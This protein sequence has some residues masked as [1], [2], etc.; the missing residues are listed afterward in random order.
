MQFP[1]LT[2]SPSYLLDSLYRL[3][4]PKDYEVKD[5]SI[6]VIIPARNEEESLE[7]CIKA[8]QAQTYQPAQIIA[9][10]DGSEDRTEEILKSFDGRVKLIKHEEPKGKAK[11]VMEALKELET[12][13]VVIV[14]G[15]TIPAPTNFEKLRI[16]FSDERVGATCSTVF[17]TQNGNEKNLMEKFILQGRLDE[18]LLSIY[19]KQGQSRRRAL[20]VASGCTVAFRTELLK[21]YGIPQRTETED[22]DLTWLLQQEGY[23]IVYCPDAITFTKEPKTSKSLR[24]Q[25]GRWY[26]GAWE[27]IFLHNTKPLKSKRKRL[28]FTTWLQMGEGIPLGAMWLSLPFLTAFRV[29][30]G[31]ITFTPEWAL[32]FYGLDAAFSL[33]PILY[34]GKKQ[35]KLKEA[36]K[37]LPAWYAMRTLQVLSLFYGL[38]KITADWI[39]GKRE[40]KAK[41]E[42]VSD[43]YLNHHSEREKIEKTNNSN[44]TQSQSFWKKLKHKLKNPLN[45]NSKRKRDFGDYFTYGISGAGAV[46]T[47]LALLGGGPLAPLIAG[48]IATLIGINYLLYRNA[49]KEKDYL[50][51]YTSIM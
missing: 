44:S 10:D 20:Y 43:Y 9:I 46:G 49:R 11:S 45:G 5:Y 40:W 24:R 47:G 35:K 30:V 51:M 16:P 1:L 12:D 25:L 31:P 22:L 2:P 21:K 6:G 28:I 13:L 14:D 33:P 48:G 19:R 26:R 7:A 37:S 32:V 18:Y 27:C 50:L 42:K 3:K 15:D 8:I 38:G 39:K 34:Y 17:S 29:K 41:W 23:D 4:K 36:V